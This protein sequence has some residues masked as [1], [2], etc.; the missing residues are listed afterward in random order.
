MSIFN[1]LS[2]EEKR[3]FARVLQ[4][5]RNKK[6]ELS[7]AK[8][9]REIVNIENWLESPY[10]VGRDGMKLYNFWKD[11]MIDIFDDNGKSF[12]EVIVTGS[13]GCLSEDTRVPT[14]IGLLS[15]KELDK[16]FKN[17]ERFKVLSEEGEKEVYYVK[18]NGYTDTIKVKT[19]NGREVEGTYNHRF[20]VVED[21]EIIWKRFDE[22]KENDKLVMTRQ[23]TPFGNKDIGDREAYVLGYMSGDGEIT[24]SNSNPKKLNIAQLMVDKD[25]SNR[26][27][28]KEGF[29]D[30]FGYVNEG[31]YQKKS[32]YKYRSYRVSNKDACKYLLDNNFGH[33]GAKY[34]NIPDFVFECKKSNI[35]SYIR[36]LFDAEGHVGKSWIEITMTSR[37]LIYD[38]ADLLSM[39]GINYY[40]KERDMGD[41]GN[42]AWRLVII[43]R[44]SWLIFKEE[45][46]FMIDY[47]KRDLG[48]LCEFKGY[49]NDRIMVPDANKVLNKMMREN[50]IK[51]Y[52]DNRNLFGWYRQNQGVTLKTVEGLYKYYPEWIKQSDY[53]SYILDKDVF[54]DEVDNIE[55]SKAYTR[56]LSIKD[57][58]TYSLKGFISHNTGKSTMAL[59]T[60][61]RK[62]YELS[63]YENIAALFDLM[64]TSM[65]VFIYFSV[66]KTQAELTGF[67]QFKSLIDSVPYFQDNFQR[68]EDINSLIQLPENLLFTHGS[69]TQHA[70]GMNLL[71]SILDEANFHK[72]E[73]TSPNQSVSKKD[74]SK[75]ANLYSSIVHRGK[76][77]F[78]DKDEDHSL[79]ILVS[80][81][82][83]SSSFTQKRIEKSVD[84]PHTKII[85]AKLWDV[86]PEKYS[87]ETFWVFIGS[88][89]MDPFIVKDTNDVNEV[90]ESEG[91]KD[92]MVNPKYNSIDFT[93][94]NAPERVQELFLEVPLN[95]KKDFK[96]DIVSALQDIGGVSI[97]P[98]GRLFSA[99]PVYNRAV[100]RGRDGGLKHPFYK[101]RFIISTG[102]DMKVRDYMREG[103]MFQNINKLRF[104]HIDQST[105]TDST[106]LGMVH[107][108]DIKEDEGVYKPHIKVDMLVKIDPPRK[109][110]EISISKIRDF[111]FY[112][113]DEYNISY[114]MVS[115]DWFGSQ[116]S[117]QVLEEEGVNVDYR[118]VDRNDEAYLSLVRMFFEDRIDLYEYKPFEE[119]LFDLIHDRKKRKVDHPSGGCFTGDTEVKLLN[120]KIKTMKELAEEGRDK[121]F[122]VYSCTEE[123]QIVPAKAYNARKTIDNSELVKVTLDNDEEIRCTPDHRFML[124]D[125]SYK[126]AQNL[127]SGDSLMPLYWKYRGRGLK[128]YE[129]VFNN[130][131]GRW[132][133]T[134][135]LVAEQMGMEGLDGENNVIHHYDIDKLNN[136]P[137]NLKVLS[138]E[139]HAK[140]HD[141]LTKLAHTPENIKKRV[142]SFKETYR[143][144]PELQR[145]FKENGA[146]DEFMDKIRKLAH[147]S[148]AIKKA[149]KT[150]R[151]RDNY[152]K[153]RQFLRKRNKTEKAREISREQ[154]RKLN[155]VY[156]QSEEGKKRRK[157]LSKTQLV[158]ARKKRMDRE[159]KDALEKLGKYRD[160]VLCPRH[161]MELVGGGKNAWKRR[162]EDIDCEENAERL[163]GLSLEEMLEKTGGI[164]KIQ[165]KHYLEKVGK[166]DILDKVNHKVKSVEFIDDREDVYDITVS[167][168]HNFALR[169]GIFVHNSKDVADGLAGAVSN[170][171]DSDMNDSSSGDD[172]LLIADVNRDDIDDVVWNVSELLGEDIDKFM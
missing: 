35:A 23:Q 50:K 121:E 135:R 134:H 61:L 143:N 51:G 58:P 98:L 22:L 88:G 33:G 131:T 30:I 149:I 114:G 106:G 74:Y 171:L 117:T 4:E 38:L 68:N 102:S 1:V 162:L 48:K 144:S 146:S 156:W 159:D 172:S 66:N 42:T 91:A 122:W 5:T 26:E 85:N 92:Y 77:R 72:G 10:Y 49:K 36:G 118:S 34:K 101:E 39:F 2:D 168:Y 89:N 163:V 151:E 139:E 62:I 8:Q 154:A 43:N 3:V 165:L 45:I 107:I 27:Y 152:E 138:R 169:S 18:D 115:Y 60:M 157:E 167:K 37:D 52:T 13:I 120:G 97:A 6:Q 25:Q 127:E 103:F 9:V 158:D 55:K 123:G 141:F 19:K 17:G 160:Y 40:I 90:L 86:K 94:N 44:K 137:E 64:S 65:I 59:F 161:A 41:K 140:R 69:D 21:G 109:P 57:S 70:I 84:D 133:L 147:T 71:G 164:S 75:V 12:N 126:E 142:K 100:E 20:R 7:E 132:R 111:L 82:T 128:G 108:A 80:S 79:S 46:G 153:E 124:R 96:V 14:S 105:T 104:V 47:K 110:K 87:D 53:L 29:K 56:D 31:V 15:L 73:E 67:G 99:K 145:K 24:Y 130:R 63:C 155:E 170:A 112:L 125:G 166:E 28:I 11:E 95:F 148:E 119:E 116:E 150:R 76:S 78:A 93:I 81:A 16:R 32:G 136:T 129:R 83:H 54:F 113:R